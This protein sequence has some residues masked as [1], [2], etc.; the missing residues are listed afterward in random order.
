[1]EDK[2]NRGGESDGPQP[3]LLL[4]SGNITRTVREI[5]CINVYLT[6]P[7]LNKILMNYKN[8]YI[9]LI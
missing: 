9:Y 7:P 2:G 8:K 6:N 5:L 3:K 4:M 1:M